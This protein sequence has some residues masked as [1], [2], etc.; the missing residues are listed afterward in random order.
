MHSI[1]KL[2]KKGLRDFGLLFGFMAAL[3]FG[4]I[5]PLLFGHSLPL[6]PWIVSAIA[7]SWALLLPQTLN[8]FY[9]VWA[10]IGL[11]MG[12]INTRLILGMIFYLIVTPMGIIRR[13]F[14]NDPM[15]REWRRT[16][17]SYRLPSQVRTGKSMEKPF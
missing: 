3:V 5:A 16:V 12:W 9:Q 17:E 6:W 15:R 10:R 14:G 4:I 1:P 11:V 2:D 13:V 7:W 8:P